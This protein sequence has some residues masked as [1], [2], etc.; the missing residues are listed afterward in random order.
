MPMANSLVGFRI[1]GLW[2]KGEPLKEWMNTPTAKCTSW[3]PMPVLVSWLDTKVPSTDADMEANSENYSSVLNQTGWRQS[4]AVWRHEFEP[5]N[6]CVKT[7]R[8]IQVWR[9]EW[10]CNLSLGKVETGGCPGFDGQPAHP[11]W[12]EPVSEVRFMLLDDTWAA[13]HVHTHVHMK[14]VSSLCFTYAATRDL[15]MTFGQGKAIK[16]PRIG[17]E[18]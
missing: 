2:V 8:K 14:P 13:P 4:S 7:K 9:R 11:G 15:V 18:L 5:Q 17:R 1:F 16:S 10:T 6:F 12:W 3:N